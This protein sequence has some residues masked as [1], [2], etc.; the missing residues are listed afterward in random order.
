MNHQENLRTQR[1]LRI[2]NAHEVLAKYRRELVHQS[3]ELAK[4]TPN[5][6]WR[7][8]VS[9]STWTSKLLLDSCEVRDAKNVLR[10]H[11]YTEEKIIASLLD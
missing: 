5:L 11:G 8:I 9:H 4:S 7:Q 1:D 2:K 10:V 6:S 3:E